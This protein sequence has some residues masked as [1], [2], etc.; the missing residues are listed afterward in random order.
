MKGTIIKYIENLTLYSTL[1]YKAIVLDHRHGYSI[2]KSWSDKTKFIDCPM[3]KIYWIREPSIKPPSAMRRMSVDWNLNPQY[4]FGF[5]ENNN[6]Y[7]IDDW[8]EFKSEW[9]YLDNFE[10]IE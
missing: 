3:V 10:V 2:R 9:Y 7:V 8:A 5:A 6:N 1:E 4:S